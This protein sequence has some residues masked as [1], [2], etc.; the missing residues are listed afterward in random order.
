MTTTSAIHPHAILDC[1]NARRFGVEYQPFVSVDGGEVLCHEA[2]AR[3]VDADGRAMPPDQVF[4][5]LHEN[6][7][8]LLHTE[9]EMKRLQLAEAPPH[10]L[11]FV[12]LDPDSYTAGEAADGGN[13]FLPLL[14]SQRNRL[15]VEIIENLHLQDV[16]ISA[17]M[18]AA[19]DGAGIRMAIDDLSS[20]RGLVS[21]AALMSAAFVKFDRS[22]LSGE[23]NARQRTLLTWALAQARD[24]GLATVLEGVETEEHL[25]LARQMGFDLAQGFLYTERFIRRGCQPTRR[26][27]SHHGAALQGK[28]A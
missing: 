3:F 15:V 7:L 5:A 11:L 6:P 8:L 25:T 4:G 17:R 24:L 10:G 20:S 28:V 21:Y 27:I 26:S 12:N 16:T 18:I 13:L 14:A 22:W 2:L 19:L 1:I 9:L 23:M